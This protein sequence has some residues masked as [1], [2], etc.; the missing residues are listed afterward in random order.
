M[1][2]HYSKYFP[3]TRR[4]T[5]NANQPSDGYALLERAGFVRGAGAAGV[6]YLLPLGWRVHRRICA[7]IFDEMER[8]GVLNVTLPILQQRELW[9]ETNRWDAYVRSKTMFRTKDEHKGGEFGL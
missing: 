5:G 1:Y 8:H 4:A 7:V 3:S 2:S 6:H 9:E